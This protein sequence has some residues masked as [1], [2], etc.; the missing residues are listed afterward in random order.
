M[1][2]PMSV[3]VRLPSSGASSHP[4]F[5]TLNSALSE[6]VEGSNLPHAPALS[7]LRTSSGCPSA[8]LSDEGLPLCIGEM[9][10]CCGAP[11]LLHPLGRFLFGYECND[12]FPVARTRICRQ[13]LGPS[14]Q[15][16]EP[17]GCMGAV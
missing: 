1:P 7:C 12:T 15:S 3:A 14:A 6:F 16:L 9:Q 5:V 11:C 2:K 4:P 10:S 17:A 8:V 13:M